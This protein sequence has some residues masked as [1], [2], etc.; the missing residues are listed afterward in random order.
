MMEEDRQTRGK[1]AGTLEH[2][3]LDLGDGAVGKALAEKESEAEF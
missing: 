3:L 1:L 2:R